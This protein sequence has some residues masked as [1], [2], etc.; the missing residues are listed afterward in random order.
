MIALVCFF[1]RS[2]IPDKCK[3]LDSAIMNH[4]LPSDIILI[5]EWL[6]ENGYFS[7][8]GMQVR[9]RVRQHGLCGLQSKQPA[10]LPSGS[11]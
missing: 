7:Q 6:N 8:G 5:N 4:G 11:T 2:R 1:F 9:R 10:C 3:G